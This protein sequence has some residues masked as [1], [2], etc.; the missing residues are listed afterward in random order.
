MKTLIDFHSHI[1]PG[2]DDG[3]SD[4]DTSLKLIDLLKNQNVSIILATPHYNAAHMSVDDFLNRR[5]LSFQKLALPGDISI[6][7]GAEVFLTRGVDSIEGLEKLCIENT[8]YILIEPP[9]EPWQDWIYESVYKIVLRGLHPIIAHV[10]RYMGVM[11]FNRILKLLEMDVIS[12]INADSLSY[13]TGRRNI[14]KL[15]KEQKFH[16]LG[17]DTHNLK[18][19]FPK[20]DI[21]AGKITKYFGADFLNH[22]DKNAALILSNK[23]PLI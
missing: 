6:K 12:Q 10:E 3:A 13:F 1:L 9:M 22:I 2:I 17:S 23:K 15:Y 19:R 18:T 7:L 21:A 20:M 5:S 14:I 16:L 8:S 11:S 4:L